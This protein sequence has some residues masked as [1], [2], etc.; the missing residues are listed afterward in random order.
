MK[1]RTPNNKPMQSNPMTQV[2]PQL[3]SA[4]RGAMHL[5]LAAVFS[6]AL[7]ASAQ[8]Y[9]KVKPYV[10]SVTPDYVVQPL[11]TVGDQVPN[12]SD[13]NRTFQMIGIPDGLGAY[14]TDCGNT[15]LFMNQ[16][17][18][19]SVVS[20]P[21]VGEMPLRGAFISRLVLDCAA[22]VVSGEVAYDSVHDESSGTVYPVAT[23][24]NATPGFARFCS[25]SL[26][27]HEA[28]LDRP[29]YFTGE[30]S[31]GADTF[32]GRGGSAV[33]V[34][35]R[36][37]HTLPKLGRIPWENALVRPARTDYTV[38]MCMEDGPT[39]PDNQLY[40]YVGAK[41]KT[42][43]ASV[44][45]RNGLDTGKLYA[46]VAD[47]GYPTNE[48]GYTNGTITGSWVEVPDAAT[49]TDV[50]LE[51]ASDATG[52][53]GFIRIEDGAWSK[54]DKNKFY[55]VTTGNG[56]GNRLGR[57][58]EVNFDKKNLLGKT[59]LTM[60]FNADA[61]DAAGGDIAFAADNMDVSKD[62]IMINEDGHSDSRPKYAARAREGSIWRLDLK[63][64]FAAKRVA[65][66]NP[67]GTEI[68]AGQTQPPAVP[69]PG[70]WETSGIIDAS[71]FF[72][73]DSWLTVVQA[74]SPTLAPAPLTVEDGQLVLLLPSKVRLDGKAECN[75]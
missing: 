71:D 58:Y 44:L 68:A 34:Y 48:V 55:F 32:D 20:Q 52:A 10:V 57:L 13:T 6:A 16:E 17:L 15:I 28:G 31:N 72:G 75:D 14:K 33:V 66:L 29:M 4:A 59:T 43:G 74:H 7:A 27:H 25:G 56:A 54:K 35:D 24:N 18:G 8:E 5:S 73:R 53:F 47:A 12:T 19:R 21:N 3:R 36:E 65:E 61:V 37:L 51:T 41:D 23:T 67:V 9:T 63:N 1:C 30:E 40:M 49:L 38:I 39:T 46:F 42:P 60:I 69:V 45:S 50:E 2:L 62:Y 64:G 11:L 70:T 22:H 26:S